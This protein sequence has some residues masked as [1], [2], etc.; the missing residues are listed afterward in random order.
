MIVGRDMPYALGIAMDFT[1]KEI[2]WDKAVVPMCSFPQINED[3]LPV[4]QQLLNEFLDKDYDDDN[5]E[6]IAV[7]VLD[8]ESLLKEE[9][10]SG[11]R[12]RGK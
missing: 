2:T 3:D 8:D 11:R 5:T 4:A 1:K 12:T 9:V 6:A 7:E 10:H